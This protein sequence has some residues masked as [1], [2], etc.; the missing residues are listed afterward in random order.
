[1]ARD[2]KETRTAAKTRWGV[3]GFVIALSAIV[4]FGAMVLGPF[5]TPADSAPYLVYVVPAMV[6]LAMAAV[7]G[8]L[9]IQ[10]SRRR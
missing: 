6:A 4:I 1:M 5:A 8:W 3:F 2:P 9:F 7:F 10:L